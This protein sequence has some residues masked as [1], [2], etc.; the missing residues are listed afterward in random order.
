MLKNPGNR[1][2]ARPACI[3]WSRYD[4][5]RCGR[6]PLGFPGPD[7]GLV[8]GDWKTHGSTDCVVNAGSFFFQQF[9][10]KTLRGLGIVYDCDG[11]LTLFR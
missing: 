5:F 2:V 3:N 1:R 7:R 10:E 4:A 11:G 8:F 9:L 6:E